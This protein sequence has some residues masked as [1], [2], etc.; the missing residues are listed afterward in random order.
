MVDTETVASRAWT[1]WQD[2]VEVV[3]GIV[4]LLS[5]LLWLSTSTKTLWT[6]V[7]L[8][9]LIAI[10]GLWSLAAPRLMASETIQ[11]VLGVLLFIAPWVMSFSA[12]SAAA[13][14]SWIAG[15][16]TVIASGI[17]LPAVSASHRLTGQH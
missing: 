11:V 17:A 15:A 7:I 4:A 10:D 16:L 5:P 8:G 9:A 3:V 14:T 2:W 12:D 1:R 6:M 13:W